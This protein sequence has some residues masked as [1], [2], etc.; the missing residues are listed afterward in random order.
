MYTTCQHLEVVAWTLI[1]LQEYVN[2]AYF[3]FINKRNVALVQ[4]TGC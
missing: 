2:L 3:K 1:S 4:H